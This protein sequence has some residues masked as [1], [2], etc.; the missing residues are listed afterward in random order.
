MRVFRCFV[1]YLIAAEENANQGDVLGGFLM[2]AQ[3][4]FLY[5]DVFMSRIIF[6]RKPRQIPFC[7]CEI[8]MNERISVCKSH[9]C[10]LHL[11]YVQNLRSLGRERK[12]ERV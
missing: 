3:E 7:M 8:Q 4:G 10:G 2:H 12:R 1:C 5:E 9:T 11:S 6:A